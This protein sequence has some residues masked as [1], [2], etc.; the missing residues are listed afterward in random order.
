MLA[1][2]YTALL[3]VPALLLAADAPRRAGWRGRDYAAA[4]ACVLA[5]AG[6]WYLR[7]FWLTGNPIYP[8][9]AL[10]LPG[11]FATARSEAF[12]GITAAWG[13]LTSK[14][15]GLP[16]AVLLIVL[17]GAA[18]AMVLRV[19]GTSSDPKDPARRGSAWRRIRSADPLAWL[20]VVGP[21]VSIAIFFALSPYPEARF[22]Y[23]AFVM[24][25]VAS[26]VAIDALPGGT[27]VRVGA[28]ATVILVPAWF[29]AF[30]FAF[31]GEG[32][33]VV[34]ALVLAGAVVTLVGLAVVA[35]AARVPA[36][37]RFAALA[38]A[39][40]L[41]MAVY[42]QWAAH[43]SACRAYAWP[44]YQ[45]PYGAAAEAW[46]WVDEHVP[47]GETLA[48]AN[49]FLVHPL[50]GFDHAR[51]VVHVP[52]RRGVTRLRD[53]PPLDGRWPGERLNAAVAAAQSAEPDA[54]Q[55]LSRLADSGA[56]HLI[57]FKDETASSPVERG[58]VDANPGRFRL[59]FENPAAAVYGL[60]NAP[61]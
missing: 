2:K 59:L 6:P 5:I 39:C 41:A 51:R 3:G 40:A 60:G 11:L 25:F 48:Y 13:V 49:T 38:G 54:A 28:A 16:G 8:L 23:P 1:T 61:P 55:W 20:I 37:G 42:T 46:L 4:V 34:G 27:G 22:V 53:L 17:I 19:R 50:S 7:N 26:A 31:D 18:G 56:T 57:I 15:Q 35:L 44:L 36:V 21:F 43:V 9:R 45:G 14:G 30:G 12:T 58:I 33:E 47:P 24:L 32:A 52:T 10:G 29:T